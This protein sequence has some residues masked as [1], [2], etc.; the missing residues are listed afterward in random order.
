MPWS[1]WSAGAADSSAPGEMDSGSD[2]SLP[3]ASSS[4][5]LTQ[6]VSSAATM[7]SAERRDLVWS[8]VILLSIF[9]I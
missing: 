8:L 7:A 5:A 2:C 6:T 9:R 4:S 1:L 3:A